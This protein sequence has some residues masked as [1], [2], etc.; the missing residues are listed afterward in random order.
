MLKNMVI[1]AKAVAG[2]LA[3]LSCVMVIMM[4]VFLTIENPSVDLLV[5]M[6]IFLVTPVLIRLLID[7]LV[8]ERTAHGTVRTESDEKGVTIVVVSETRTVRNRLTGSTKT[9]SVK[10]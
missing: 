2:I 8:Y 4:I 5:A 9:V 6:T 1:A 3:L 7:V 10:Y